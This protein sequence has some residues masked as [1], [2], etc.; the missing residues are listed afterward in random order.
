MITK[1]ER[2]AYKLDLPF[3]TLIHPVFHISQLKKHVGNHT[4]QGALP[5]FPQTHDLQ[6]RTILERR[7]TRRK[8]QAITQVLVHW[9]GFP[10]INAT[11]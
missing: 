10:H 6:P 3:T 4:V 9:D 1:V 2:V 7:M 8:N 11:W 5:V